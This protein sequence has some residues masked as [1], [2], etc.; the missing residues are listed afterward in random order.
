[1]ADPISIAASVAGLLALADNL[2]QRTF[3]YVAAVR[4]SKTELSNLASELAKLCGVLKGV[5]NVARE[6]EG[7]PPDTI[8]QSENFMDCKQTLEKLNAVLGKHND[9]N[10]PDFSIGKLRSKLRWPFTKAETV[11]LIAEV[12]RHQ[13]RIEL[14]LSADSITVMLHAL[15][16]Q[17]ETT[18]ELEDLRNDIHD[19]IEAQASIQLSNDRK[20]LLSSLCP[21]NPKVA[22]QL[23]LKSRHP[24]TC[25]WVLETIEFKNWM[26][27]TNAILWLYGI[28][29]AGKSVAAASIIAKI[30]D[31]RT[32]SRPLAYF[33]CDYK[34]ANTKIL[35][36][37]LCSL[38]AQIC[39]QNKP[40]L[41]AVEKFA[42]N[43][44]H[45][46]K[47]IISS[48]PEELLNLIFTIAQFFESVAVVVDGLDEC[49]DSMG[50]VVELLS[51]LGRS[52][53]N[54]R[55]LYLSQDLPEIKNA[56]EQDPKV[57]IAAQPGDIRLYVLAEIERRTKR[58]SLR[59]KDP[60]LEAVIIETLV[61][62]SGG[63]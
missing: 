61:S 6:L 48:N 49:G 18:T 37:I 39:A 24:G 16:K 44:G 23:N 30:E 50:E 36:T 58:R 55:A 8:S 62:R 41:A 4:Q 14:A 45:S 42:E 35:S 63:M 5:E 29:G 56:F 32:P 59:L 27:S 2:V 38:I 51:K 13:Q 46:T 3:K 47:S 53:S 54:I 20:E 43:C 52:G 9:L 21:V 34:S 31:V 7:L 10:E 11:D 26:A 57:L 15:S 22:Q 60:T 1:M 19:N 28:P 12:Q 17:Q 33:Y 25:S 40:S